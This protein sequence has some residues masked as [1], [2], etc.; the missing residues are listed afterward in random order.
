MDSQ[1]CRECHRKP[2]VNVETALEIS[3]HILSM[4]TDRGP[5]CGRSVHIA[6][7]VLPSHLRDW[8][9]RAVDTADDGSG[10]GTWT[11]GGVSGWPAVHAGE[12]I[13]SG[14]E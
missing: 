2:G 5:R 13:V 9:Q 3:D 10:M 14:D 11:A 7:L 4:A 6:V 12:L 8:S 1:H